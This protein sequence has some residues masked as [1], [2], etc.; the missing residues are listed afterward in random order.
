MNGIGQVFLAM[1]IA[2]PICMVVAFSVVYL[3][4][5]LWPFLLVGAVVALALV[6]AT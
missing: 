6:W 2:L 4:T 1:A 5:L 3:V